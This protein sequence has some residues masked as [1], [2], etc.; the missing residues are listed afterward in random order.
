MHPSPLG[1]YTM[2]LGAQFPDAGRI[3]VPPFSGSSS[4]VSHF[5]GHLDPSS[6]DPSE[7][8]TYLHTITA[9]HI[10]AQVENL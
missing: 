6:C 10:L 5:F 9:S 7:R 2:S 4:P 1:L 3:V 8:T